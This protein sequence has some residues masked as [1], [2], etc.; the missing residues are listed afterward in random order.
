VHALTGRTAA[1]FGFGD[2]G[3]VAPGK[4]G[5]LA[6]FALDELTLE[7]ETRVFDVPHGTW[8]FTR[9]PAGFRATVVAGTPTWLDGEA[10]GARPGRVLRPT[11]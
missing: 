4:A 6:V 2:R 10:T 11:G 8:R 3:V 1:F 7:R 5:D 9:P